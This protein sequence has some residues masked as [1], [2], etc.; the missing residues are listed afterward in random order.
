[1]MWN[2]KLQELNLTIILLLFF[3]NWNMGICF[4]LLFAVEHCTCVKKPLK[5]TRGILGT[6]GK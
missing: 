6:R 3:M 5:M 4:M 2:H 1:M